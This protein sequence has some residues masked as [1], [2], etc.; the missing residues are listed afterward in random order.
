MLPIRLPA[1]STSSP[2]PGLPKTSCCTMSWRR[3][4]CRGAGMAGELG[5]LLGSPCA[6]PE[7]VGSSQPARGTS[8]SGGMPI[9]RSAAGPLLQGHGTGVPASPWD[10]CRGLCQ[11]QGPTAAPQPPQGSAL[12]KPHRCQTSVPGHTA[13]S[14]LRPSGTGREDMRPRT[15]TS[16]NICTAGCLSHRPSPGLPAYLLPYVLLSRDGTNAEN[17]AQRCS[18][19]NVG[20]ERRRHRPALCQPCHP[21]RGAVTHRRHPLPS[22]AAVTRCC[23]L[24]AVLDGRGDRRCTGAS[25]AGTVSY[26]ISSC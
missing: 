7:L 18:R 11:L 2:Q 3:L 14:L 5:G 4:G 21:P 17:M 24:G 15:L 9:P 22:P 25:G 12:T 6:S 20:W 8:S 26:R 13:P 23:L 1:G 10:G 16:G 19:H